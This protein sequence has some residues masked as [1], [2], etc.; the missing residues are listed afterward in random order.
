MFSTYVSNLTFTEKGLTRISFFEN[1]W[2]VVKNFRWEKIDASIYMIWNETGRFLDI[3]DDFFCFIIDSKTAIIQTLFRFDLGIKNYH[4]PGRKTCQ[5]I[6]KLTSTPMI[7]YFIHFSRAR[8]ISLRGKS[9]KISQKI[10]KND[11][12]LPAKTKSRKR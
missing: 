12:G 8:T 7:I 1:H 4:M 3:M 11:S 6:S 2:N 5:N 10:R 9:H